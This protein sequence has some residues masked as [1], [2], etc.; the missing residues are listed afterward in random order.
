MFLSSALTLVQDLDSQI[1]KLGREIAAIKASPG[2]WEVLKGL[3]QAK[4]NAEQKL[5]HLQQETEQLSNQEEKLH[6]KAKKLH[7]KLYGGSTCNIK[8]LKDTEKEWQESQAKLAPLAELIITNLEEIESLQKLVAKLG[9]DL[10]PREREARQYDAHLQRKI[11]KYQAQISHLQSERPQLLANLPKE[12][13]YAYNNLF[14]SK[15]GLAV[16]FLENRI[17]TACRVRVPEPKI[18]EV[19]QDRLTFCESCGRILTIRR[20]EAKTK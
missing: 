7:D 14:K 20:A 9:Q 1:A 15:G 17:C 8:E 18:N 10:E 5:A 19:F 2:Q 6:E 4:L 3:Q 11:E 13:L 12:A 16:S